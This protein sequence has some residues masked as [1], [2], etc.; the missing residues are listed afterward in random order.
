MKKI[1]KELQAKSIEDLKKETD[2]L[3]AEIAKMRLEH[4]I[5]PQK[6]TN[7]VTKK[8][9]RLA[10]ILTMITNKQSVVSAKGGSR[11]AG[12]S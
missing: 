8:Q 11:F 7:T 6:D 12:K 1:T 10:A 3:R 5:K 4:G 2:V 9:K